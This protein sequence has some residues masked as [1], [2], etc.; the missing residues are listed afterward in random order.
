M[1]RGDV[2]DSAGAFVGVSKRVSP[3]TKSPKPVRP[4]FGPSSQFRGIGVGVKGD[5]RK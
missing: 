1:A 2:K 4:V 5:P 3:S